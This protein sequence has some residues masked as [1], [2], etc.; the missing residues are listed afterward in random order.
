LIHH[1]DAKHGKSHVVA[2]AQLSS[3][4]ADCSG[5]MQM[6]QAHHCESGLILCVTRLSVSPTP[7]RQV[8]LNTSAL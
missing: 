4:A 3:F 1:I 7:F 8:F 5:E 2:I 6:K